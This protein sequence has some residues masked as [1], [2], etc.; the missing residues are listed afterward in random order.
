DLEIMRERLIELGYE[1]G[2]E[3]YY[4][5]VDDL[6]TVEAKISYAE[7]G[8]EWIDKKC[9]EA[10]ERLIEMGRIPEP[11]RDPWREL[12]P[13]DLRGYTHSIEP[14]QSRALLYDIHELEERDQVDVVR[15]LPGG[16]Y[17]K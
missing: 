9:E 16:A 3:D 11:E 10:R 1:P 4:S 6:D 2:T 12:P 13:G 8:D 15:V 7:V 14:E 17:V 5:F